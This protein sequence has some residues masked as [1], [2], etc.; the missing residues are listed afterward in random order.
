MDKLSDVICKKCGSVND[1]WTEMKSGQQCAY[2]NGCDSYIKN[3]PY[4]IPKFYIGKYKGETISSCKDL[5]Y[6]KWFL[7]KTNPKASQKTAV[8]NR[9]AELEGR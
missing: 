5:S 4:Q 6:L 2:C 9:I 1:Y 3:V 7:E 8:E